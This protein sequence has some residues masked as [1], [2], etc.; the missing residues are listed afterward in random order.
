MPLDKD[1]ITVVSTTGQSEKVYFLN[2]L[3]HKLCKHIGIHRFLYLPGAPKSLLGRD[4]LEQLNATI[5]F[6]KGQ[7]EFKIEDTKLTEILSLALIQI[8][9]KGEIPQDILDQVY[10][11]VGASGTPD[12]DKNADPI[13]ITL[14][15]GAPLVKIKQY[16]LKL[17]D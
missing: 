7:I 5:I 3:K 16:P 17:E 8:I 1:F 13:E 9:E 10:P 2:P 12:R 11:G 6:R 15:P 14:N 4:L